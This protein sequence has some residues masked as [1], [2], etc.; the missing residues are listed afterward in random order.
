M[1]EPISV[2]QMAQEYEFVDDAGACLHT[3]T[4]DERVMLEDFGEGV[5]A[6][7]AQPRISALEAQVARLTTISNEAIGLAEHRGGLLA[8]RDAQ[9]ARLREAAQPIARYADD[10][11]EQEDDSFQVWRDASAIAIT[12]GNLRRLRAALSSTAPPW[13]PTHWHHSTNIL[14]R[15]V[16]RAILTGLDDGQEIVIVETRDGQSLGYRVG[17]FDAVFEPLPSAAAQ[18]P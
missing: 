7:I 11:A 10:Y 2:H 12:V 9:V 3:P 8:K 14:V 4:D 16:S 15:A 1:A 18:E 5:L 6:E 17:T 13:V